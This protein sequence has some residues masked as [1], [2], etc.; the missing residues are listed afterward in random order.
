MS[1]KILIQLIFLVEREEGLDDAFKLALVPIEDSLQQRFEQIR[2][3]S[4]QR[5]DL[6]FVPDEIDVQQKVGV[7]LAGRFFAESEFKAV[8]LA[9]HRVYDFFGVFLDSVVSSHGVRKPIALE[10]SPKDGR[11]LIQ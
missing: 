10:R 5:L 9:D 4:L 6:I 7:F 11:K 2:G 8:H 1:A 3:R